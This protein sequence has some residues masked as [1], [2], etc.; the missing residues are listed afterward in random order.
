MASLEAA[1]EGLRAG[2]ASMGASLE[3]MVASGRARAERVAAD[4]QA[5]TGMAA[6]T[7]MTLVSLLESVQSAGRNHRDL[8][9]SNQEIFNSVEV[10]CSAP[11]S[12]LCPPALSECCRSIT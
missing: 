6:G 1:N 3:E 12:K 9:Q 5:V 4:L 10:S 2:L 7:Q 8:E 11:A